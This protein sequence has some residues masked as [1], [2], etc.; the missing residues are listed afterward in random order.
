MSKGNLF[1]GFGRGKVGDVVFSRLDGEQ[2]AR[3]RNR[4]PRNPKTPLQLL[5]RVVTKTTSLGFSLMQE[6]TNHSFQGIDGVT[7]N[8]ARFTQL[9]VE[10][11]RRQLAFEINSGEA[12][13]ILSSSQVNFA[14][15]AVTIAPIN[16]YVVSEGKIP[17]PSFSIMPVSTSS[18]NAVVALPEVE[19]SAQGFQVVTYADV[20]AALG[21]QRGDQLTVCMCTC[22][23]TEEGSDGLFNGFRYGRFILEPDDGDLSHTISDTTHWN[24]KSKGLTLTPVATASNSV[25]GFSIDGVDQAPGAQHS[26]A[27]GCVIVSRL[28]GSVWERSTAR[29]ALRPWTVGTAWH[30]AYDHGTEFLGDAILSYMSGANSSLYLNQADF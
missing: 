6:I 16:A 3:A 26:L 27:A 5:Q 30:L 13:D 29:L 2:V 25:L 23:D 22:D 28:R 8:Q 17:A 7:M 10:A 24:V 9:N 1:L 20:I 4:S 11:F 21:L 15:A 14:G 18:A 12:E 19:Y